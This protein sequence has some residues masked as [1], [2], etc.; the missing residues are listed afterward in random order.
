[1]NRLEKA[2]AQLE[3]IDI[4]TKIDNDTLYVCIGD[5]QLELSDYEIDYRAKEY[6]KEQLE[7]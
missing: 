4:W 1:M 6:D 5:S 7:M 3:G 2:Q